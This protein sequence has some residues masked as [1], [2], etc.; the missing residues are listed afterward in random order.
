MRKWL[1]PRAFLLSALLIAVLQTTKVPVSGITA[2]WLG[3]A[4]VTVFLGGIFW[5]VIGTY[6]YNRFYKR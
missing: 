5:G 6:L 1:H 2:E 4:T 3:T